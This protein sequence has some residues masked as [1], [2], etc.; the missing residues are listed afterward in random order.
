MSD[1]KGKENEGESDLCDSS[2]RFND[3]SEEE[4]I[5][6]SETNGRVVTVCGEPPSVECEDDVEQ[7]IQ[8]LRS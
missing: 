6:K 8:D 2:Y 5:E 3:D 7:I 4:P 1:S